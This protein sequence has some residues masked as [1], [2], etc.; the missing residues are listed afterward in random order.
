[1]DGQDSQAICGI[2]AARIRELRA[3]EERAY[4]KA[5]PRSQKAAGHG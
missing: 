3:R 1:M 2:D 5:R 4:A